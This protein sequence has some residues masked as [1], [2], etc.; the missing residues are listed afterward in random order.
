MRNNGDFIFV[1]GAGLRYECAGEPYPFKPGFKTG[2][3]TFG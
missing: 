1:G 3:E 2:V